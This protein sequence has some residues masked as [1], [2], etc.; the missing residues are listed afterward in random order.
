M[1]VDDISENP[2]LSVEVQP[3]EPGVDVTFDRDSPPSV[4]KKV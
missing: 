4:D 2:S 1:T 3:V